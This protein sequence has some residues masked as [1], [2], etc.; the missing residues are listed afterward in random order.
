MNTYEYPAIAGTTARKAVFCTYVQQDNSHVCLI[1]VCVISDSPV[2]PFVTVAVSRVDDPGQ[3]QQC[4][5]EMLEMTS[6][7]T[8]FNC[9]LDTY[10]D[11]VQISLHATE[12]NVTL[13]EVEIYGS[14]CT[15]CT[16]NIIIIAK[17]Q[18][19]MYSVFFSKGGCSV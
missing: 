14:K 13:C 17:L 1:F 4:I 10:G 3:E 9:E 19:N 5:S 11:H 16:D 15:F 18:I 12:A 8:S 6:S 2:L 7:T